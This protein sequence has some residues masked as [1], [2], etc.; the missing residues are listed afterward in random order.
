[1]PPFAGKKIRRGYFSDPGHFIKDHTWVHQWGRWHVF[2]I[3]GRQAAGFLDQIDEEV[4]HASTADF[5]DWRVHASLPVEGAPSVIEKDGVFYFYSN[6]P[7]GTEEKPG[8][9]LVTSKNLEDWDVYEKNPVYVPNPHFYAW[10]AVKHCRD[11]HVMPFENGYLMLFAELTRDSIGCVGAI[12]SDDLVSWSD[13]GPIFLLDKPNRGYTQW[14][15][16]GYG[17]PESPFLMEK[18]GRWHLWVTDNLTTRLI[19]SGR[20][21]P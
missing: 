20:I 19:I 16:V 4:G 8:I 13:L 6:R 12:R 1:M 3:R 14:N 18:D 9:I 7:K 5:V 15:E 17:I 10:P 11:Y 2:Y 21:V